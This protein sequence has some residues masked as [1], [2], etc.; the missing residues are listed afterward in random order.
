MSRHKFT[1]MPCTVGCGRNTM[2]PRF[3]FCREC[4][5]LYGKLNPRPEWVTL[6]I[7]SHRHERYV[8]E[9]DRVR[10]MSLDTIMERD[11]GEEWIQDLC[12][13]YDGQWGRRRG[14]GIDGQPGLCLDSDAGGADYLVD[15]G[16]E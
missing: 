14:Y 9:R 5:E 1:G 11:D 13:L 7:R 15:A 3:P 2:H 16:D 6:L 8:M 4:W 10:S 12:S